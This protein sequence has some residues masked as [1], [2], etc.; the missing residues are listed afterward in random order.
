MTNPTPDLARNLLIAQLHTTRG[1]IDDFIKHGGD[2]GDDAFD[3]ISAA[4]TT[5]DRLVWAH[6]DRDTDTGMTILNDVI[7][8][9]D[10]DNLSSDGLCDE[11]NDIRQGGVS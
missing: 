8:P 9:T 11:L 10:R 6:Y 5:S 3:A 2:V 4:L 1:L 7:N